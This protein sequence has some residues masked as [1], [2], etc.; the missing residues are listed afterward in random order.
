MLDRLTDDE[1]SAVRATIPLGHVTSP[2]DVNGGMWM[3]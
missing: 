2:I 1:L 3:G